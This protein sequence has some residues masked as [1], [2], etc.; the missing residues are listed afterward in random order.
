MS[1]RDFMTRV[2]N[3]P[4][5]AP[6]TNAIQRIATNGQDPVKL[7]PPIVARASPA[8]LETTPQLI[9]PRE[10]DPA[11][12][13]DDGQQAEA[14]RHFYWDIESRSATVLG[15]GKYA[16][17]V[18]AYAEHPTTQVLCVSYALGNGPIET[19][20]PGQLLSSTI[21]AAAA[22]PL[23]SWVAHNAAF[24]RAM[25]EDILVP[26][27]GWPMVPA[28]RHVC[29]MSLALAHAYPGGLE[30]AAEILGLVNRKDVA[31]EKIVRVMWKPRK[32]RRGEDPTK[33]YWIDTPELRAENILYNKQDVA[34]E[35]ELHRHPKLTPLPAS[36]Q[37]AWV[38]D[39][40][41]N[42]DGA[43]I[44]APLAEPA[45]LVAAQAHAELDERMRHETGGAVAAATKNEKLKAW[46]KSQGVELPRR[47][48][49]H[50][51]GM[52]LE[53]CLDA[54]DIE[55]LLA[56]DLAHPRARAALEIRLQ[57]A[58]SA[59]TKIERMLRTRCADGRVRGLFRFHG[60]TTGR[61][62][63]SGFQPQNLKRPDILKTDEA[64][65]E[66]I[67]LVMAKDHAALKER[68]HDVLGVI[69]D[70]CRSMIIPA[71]GYR[72]IIGDFSAIEARVLAFLAGDASKLEQFRQFDL[73]LGRDLYCITAE[74]VLGLAEVQDKSPERQLGKVFELG[75]GYQMGGE[76]L[77][78]TI[79]KANISG[80]RRDHSRRRDA[81]GASLARREPV[82]R[83]ILG[84]ARS[85]CDSGRALSRNLVPLP[86]RLF[87]HARWGAGP[88]PAVR[89]RAELPGSDD[90]AGA[91]R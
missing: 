58:Q 48:K 63:G 49:K 64:I 75:L 38:L 51:S 68:Y 1:I 83:R 59:H 60:A 69:G 10:L 47:L 17:G 72:F 39:A 79:A 32:P 80:H 16:V 42:D 43:Y 33:I 88:A 9:V 61:W 82:H 87:R 74:Q 11:F 86:G 29:T 71:P 89:A 90:P 50:K 7:T 53:D 37:D 5:A 28:D 12:T 23:C 52:Q 14:C 46:L 91:F 85:R 81:V 6:S 18:R 4:A 20:V 31:R 21:L 2:L 36:E 24:E 26:L 15:N 73:G 70:L 13:C 45:V 56:G 62:S 30:A 19:W 84:R 22:D 55:K 3:T 34:A 41:I 78:T 35:R 27:H 66:A 65:A 54:D 76:R 40:E 8:V 44:D 77:L 57:A 67:L 25:L